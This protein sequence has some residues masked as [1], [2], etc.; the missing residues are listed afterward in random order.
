MSE[1]NK[2]AHQANYLTFK[3]RLNVYC[4]NQLHSLYVIT[5]PKSYGI[6]VREHLIK[7]IGHIHVKKE[8]IL[9]HSLE[10]QSL[11]DVFKVIE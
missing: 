4:S 1:D 6:F 9:P 5:V 2:S 10:I 3:H 8:G 7:C 11:N